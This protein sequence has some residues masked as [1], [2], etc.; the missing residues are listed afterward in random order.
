MNSSLNAISV[1][2]AYPWL[3]LLLIPAAALMLFPYLRLPKRRRRT[4]NRI[5]SLVLHGLIMVLCVLMVSGMSFHATEVSKKTDVILLVDLSDSNRSSEE[6]MNAF[7]RGLLAS[8]EENY[9]VGIVTFA[10]GTVFS[11]EIRSNADSVYEDY[12]TNDV[13]PLGNATDIAS[14][15]DY[16]RSA[17][18]TPRNGR[19][20]LLSDGLETDGNAI[21]AVKAMA[22]EGIRVDTVYFPPKNAKGEVQILSVDVPER[23]SL[24]D[25]IK[26][27]VS[28]LSGAATSAH[29]KLFDNGEEVAG[30][31]VTLSGTEEA[32]SFDYEVTTSGLHS[33]Y[34]TLDAS[35]DSLSQNNE[36]YSYLNIYISIQ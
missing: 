32:F 36:Y 24:G 21:A 3:L 8:K 1:T 7:I 19:V 29:L 10:N 12:L 14:A 23:V 5:I 35:G 11:A 6:D 2:F 18:A 22:D 17:L 26:V 9:K 33:F 13:K 15:F 28:L 25:E 31:D 27:T 20:I 16:A 30:R 34:V 4:R